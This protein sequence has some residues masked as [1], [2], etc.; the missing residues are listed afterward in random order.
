MFLALILGGDFYT[1]SVLAS[2]LTK[3]VI[4]CAKI[5][6]DKQQINALKAEAM[7]IMVSAIRVGQSKFVTVPIDEDSNERIM[8]CIQTLS[9][10][11]KESTIQEVFLKDTKAAYSKMIAAQ[12]VCDPFTHS[13][14][15]KRLLL[16]AC[17]KRLLR[18][19]PPRQRR[20]QWSKLTTC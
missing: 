18:R 17:R 12:E 11:D 10:L 13:F 15:V 3:L 1:A 6:Q 20:R 7:L 4:R 9:D 14:P 19:K 5:S 16:F 2:A 8:N